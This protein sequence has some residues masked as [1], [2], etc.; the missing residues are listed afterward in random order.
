MAKFKTRAR[1]IDMLGRQQIAN[2]STAISELFKNSYDAYA[3]NIE[4]DYFRYSDLFVLRDDGFGMTE[5]EFTERWLAVG[6]EHKY[7]DDGSIKIIPPKGKSLRPMMGEKGIGR[8]AISTIGSQVLVLSR[9]ERNGKMFPTVAAFLN[10][11]IFEC[12]GIDLEEI[13]IPVITYPI[14]TLPNREDVTTIVEL[15]KENIIKLQ[16]RIP[17]KLKNQILTDLEKFDFDPIEF[18]KVLARFTL[19]A[20]NNKTDLSLTGNKTG[21]HF[22][23]LPSSNQ[24]SS[25]INEDQEDEGAPPLI[26]TLIGFTNSMKLPAENNENDVTTKE[27]TKDLTENKLKEDSETPFSKEKIHTAFRDHTTLDSNKDLINSQDFFTLNDFDL[28]DHL[29]EGVFDEEGNFNGTVRVY[30]TDPIKHFI[31]KPKGINE[32]T[33]CGSFGLKFGYIQ[34]NL[35]ESSLSKEELTKILGKLDKIG[36]LYIYKDNIRVQPYGNYDY[37]YLGLEMRRSKGA[38]RYFFSYR[39]L[40]GYI[41]V[42]KASNSNLAEKAGREGFIDNEAYKQFK[43]LLVN[44]FLQLATDFFREGGRDLGAFKEAKAN[45]QKSYRIRQAVEKKNDEARKKLK[46]DLDF[47]INKFDSETPEKEINQI[48]QEF[49]KSIDMFG[50]DLLPEEIADQTLKLE[51]QYE[52]KLKRIRDKYHIEKPKVGFDEK[53]NKQWEYYRNEFL[54]FETEVFSKA[55]KEINLITQ[56]LLSNENTSSPVR[57]WVLENSQKEIKKADESIK[58]SYIEAKNS[59]LRLSQEVEKIRNSFSQEI[60]N[61]ELKLRDKLIR[62]DE[63]TFHNAFTEFNGEL[64]NALKIKQSNLSILHEKTSDLEKGLRTNEEQFSLDE[65]IA[66]LEE[67]NINLQIR[68]DE[69][70]ELAQLGMAVSTIGHEFGNMI[71]EI[72]DSIRRLGVWAEHDEDLNNLYHNLKRGFDHL[73]EYLSS[74]TPLQRRLYRSKVEIRGG[75][76]ASYI[77]RIFS[78]ALKENDIKLISSENFS[79]SII[80]G[81]PSTFYPV[82]VNLVDN[83]IYWLKDRPTPREIK[84]DAISDGSLTVSDTGP[85]IHPIDRSFIFDG[86]FT[87]KPGGRGLGLKISKEVLD[88]AGYDL[89]L[90]DSIKQEGAVFIIR[91][92]Q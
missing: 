57:K 80:V 91:K 43:K 16:E 92:K 27:N 68:Y 74:F 90:G 38:G 54:F 2:I 22:Y 25:E 85:G 1:A 6:T 40:F 76:I 55:Q 86:G 39:R 61:L 48:I 4:A 41:E 28:T 50:K 52:T 49:K 81:Y 10:W 62:G 31:S 82:F 8:L 66:A 87:R 77:N 88:K 29:V 59:I 75:Q 78:N 9:A 12:P 11:R 21:T 37:D 69:S 63:K 60:K 47:T 70:V 67:E 14:G 20:T 71:N 13:D 36:G 64:E 35:W 46:R 56:Q 18:D 32:K 79:E 89:M 65:T 45:L 34:G 23:I 17:D 3:D 5:N 24:L 44:L 83:A 26:K 7:S 84:L 53:L 19:K 51:K 73:D 33:K 58:K 72:R 30:K 42:S 15:F